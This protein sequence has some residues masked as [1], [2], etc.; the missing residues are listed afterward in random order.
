MSH[1]IPESKGNLGIVGLCPDELVED[2]GQFLK[3]CCVLSRSGYVHVRA[4]I[5]GKAVNRLQLL[6]VKT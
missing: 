6:K 5:V 3:R 2:V 4:V 1:G